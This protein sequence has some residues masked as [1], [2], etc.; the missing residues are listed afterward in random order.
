[1]CIVTVEEARIDAAAA[2]AFKEAVRVATEDAP[3]LVILDLRNVA[4]IDSSGLGAIVAAM[5]FLAPTRKLVL[6][7]ATPSV[8]RVFELTR[9]DSVFDL[10]PT[11]D[12]ALGKCGA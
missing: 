6:A 3:P 7:G 2:L 4:F 10:F 1:L 9:M 12:A 8:R 11:L 5:K